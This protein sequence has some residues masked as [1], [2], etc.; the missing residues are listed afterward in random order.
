MTAKLRMRQPDTFCVEER[1]LVPSCEYTLLFVDSNI[2]CWH[3]RVCLVSHLD[4][5][6]SRYVSSLSAF[7]HNEVAWS[8]LRQSGVREDESLPL[9][10]PTLD[11]MSGYGVSKRISEYLVVQVRVC[12]FSVPPCFH[13]QSA[14]AGVRRTSIG[15]ARLTLF[16]GRHRSSGFRARLYGLPTLLQTPRPVRR[17]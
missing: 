2:E 7:S 8:R 11:G 3:S 5:V 10:E 13:A 12:E 6:N 1:R 15:K 16:G 17:L 9:S 14:V 4:V